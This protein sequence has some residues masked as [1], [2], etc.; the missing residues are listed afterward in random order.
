MLLAGALWAMSGAFDYGIQNVDAKILWSKISYFGV[1]SVG[2][3]WLLFAM[4]YGRPAAIPP[5]F[6]RISIW[7]IPLVSL[8]LVLSNELHGLVWHTLTPITIGTHKLLLYGHGIVVWIIAIYS[9]LFMLLGT[10]MLVRTVLRSMQLYRRQAAWLLFGISLPWMNNMLYL[11]G[12]SPWHGQ[13]LTPIAFIFMGVAMSY[14]IYRDRLFDIVPIARESLIERMSDGVL[15]LDAENRFLDVNPAA[16]FMIGCDANDVVGQPAAGAPP[17]WD[18]LL[19]RFSGLSNAEIEVEIQSTRWVDLSMSSIHDRRGKITGRKK[20]KRKCCT[21]TL[22]S[23]PAMPT[24][25][26]LR[27]P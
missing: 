22:N 12:F 10:I 25:M 13:D 15:V 9:Y 18:K 4:Q 27:I 19:L 23:K 14:G 11:L 26:H 7:I 5:R 3:L 24:W 17:P 16:E 20:R 21:T 2:P 8:L 1:V 6:L